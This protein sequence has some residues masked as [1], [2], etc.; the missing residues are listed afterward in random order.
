MFG[1]ELPEVVLI[2]SNSS[3]TILQ[4]RIPTKNRKVYKKK[5]KEILYIS[6]NFMMFQKLSD[7]NITNI[8][9]I[10]KTI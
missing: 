8:F 6:N 4:F 7:V 3:L 2:Y 5:Y 1:E 10:N 9:S